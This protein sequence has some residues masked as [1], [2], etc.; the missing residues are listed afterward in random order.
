M[1][2]NKI[3]NIYGISKEKAEEIS[4]QAMKES[5]ALWEKH[6]KNIKDELALFLKSHLII[7]RYVDEILALALPNAK[8]ILEKSG[9]ARKIILLEALNLMP[10]QDIYVKLRTI[11]KLR[12][13][14]AHYLDK[15]FSQEEEQ[16]IIKGLGIK[17]K[18]L[19]FNDILKVL[20]GLFGYL[21]ATKTFMALFPFFYHSFNALD[22]IK[23]DRC[24]HLCYTEVL[25]KVYPEILEILNNLKV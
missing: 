6:C 19:N 22:L 5:N 7:E 8:S 1:P 16:K 15:K 20:H 25:K 18:S 10:D 11:N 13:Y 14:Y 2:N 17:E 12:N 9:F 4:S 24:F 3:S 23:N 21:N